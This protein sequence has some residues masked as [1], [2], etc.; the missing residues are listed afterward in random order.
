MHVSP[1]ERGVCV[2]LECGQG[3]DPTRVKV[4]EGIIETA[5]YENAVFELEEELLSRT[6]VQVAADEANEV[7]HSPQPNFFDTGDQGDFDIF[8]SE[9]ERLLTVLERFEIDH[10]RS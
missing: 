8:E 9:V 5:L 6:P 10:T 2:G 1:I 4:L 7:E 3:S